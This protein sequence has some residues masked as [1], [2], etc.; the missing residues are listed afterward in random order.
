MQQLIS[1]YRMPGDREE[2]IAAAIAAAGLD[3][4]E[5]LIYGTVPAAIPFRRVTRGVH[6]KYWT[7]WV[8]L[9]RG[10][11][12]RLSE[13]F[14]S[15]E[16]RA[17]FYGARDRDG[18]IETVRANIRAALAEN[19]RYLVWHIQDCTNGEAWSRNFHYTDREVLQAAAELYQE[20]RDLIPDGVSVLFE[21]IFWPGLCDMDRGKLAAFFAA[22][23]DDAHTGL[24]FDTGHFM[25]TNWDL[26]TE[27][28]AADCICQAVRRMGSL[29]HRIHGIHLS[30]S[31][32]GRY[33]KTCPRKMP[34]GCTTEMLFR[35]I[36]SIDQ[37]RPFTTDAAARIVDTIQ[38]EYLTHELFG[39]TFSEALGKAAGQMKCVF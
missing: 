29:K 11:E 15:R 19:P 36:S 12:E 8:D 17:A 10:E 27:A 24:M 22:V 37:H 21:N 5:N 32:S 2:D 26:A 16:A 38:P 7:Y 23:D 1:Y 35:H 14:P 34:A 6:L 30:C 39:D 9:W 20:C 28:E 33:Q 3:G 18:W 4:V 25:S 13:N 31:L